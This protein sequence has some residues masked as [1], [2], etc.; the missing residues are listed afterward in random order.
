MTTTAPAK[1]TKGMSAKNDSQA[2]AQDTDPVAQLPGM[3]ISSATPKGEAPEQLP[4]RAQPQIRYNPLIQGHR[5][6]LV[7][8]SI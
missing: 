4:A 6:L 5:P 2:S 3:F 1:R 8:W 7:R